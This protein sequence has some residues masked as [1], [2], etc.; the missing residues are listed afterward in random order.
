MRFP[1]CRGGKAGR[2]TKV[3]AAAVLV[4]SLGWAAPAL[5]QDAPAARCGALTSLAGPTLRIT[6]ARLIPAGPLRTRRPP[7]PGMTPVVLPAHC[8]VR[9]VLNPRTGADGRAY[10]LGFELRMPAKW[11]GRFLFQGGAGLDGAVRP[12]VGAVA[13]GARPA[14]VRGFAVISSDGGHEGMDASFA[15][16]QQAKLDYAYAGLG[17]VAAL[18]KKIVAQYY[19]KKASYSYF[20]GC[21]NGGREAMMAA[22][23][24]PGAFNGIVAGDPGFNLSAAAIAE[25]WDVKHLMAIAPKD[26]QGRPILSEALTKADL[27]LVSHAVLVACDGLDGLKDGM[28]N[29]MAACHFDPKVLACK[30]GHSRP[31]LALKKVAAIEAMFRGPHDSQ[32]RPLYAN[33]PYDAG[34]DT[35]GWRM[36]RL[37]TS[38][39]AKPNAM[40]ATLGLNSMRFYFL[41][42]PQPN[43]TPETFDFDRARAD[44]EKT[45]AINDVT[46]MLTS[47][48]AHGGK[49][50]VY[51]GLSDP[52]FSADAI[53]S[54][55]RRLEE[56]DSSAYRWA[57]LFLVPG[58]NHCFGGPA[59]DRFDAL[60]AIQRWTEAAK[61]PTRIVAHGR[62]FPKVHRP[63]CPYPQYA[64][65]KGGDVTE[66]KSF[67]CRIDKADGS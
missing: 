21:S 18:G 11:N 5:A 6:S 36:W 9:G 33:W 17:P 29:N 56:K 22:E 45:R 53:M 44:T 43:M 30:N 63:L 24:F 49:L 42:P 47:Y 4:S 23:R 7:F 66:A 54:W 10:G 37:G 31:C 12:A 48:A 34:I 27:S 14:L 57:R 58:M 64:H 50:I 3:F 35:M 39:T 38:K 41:T 55:Y 67:V 62:A 32:G 25:M 61:P 40:D 13:A 16:D 26:A 8:L 59:T 2:I 60:S 52:V 28:I 15:A 1:T 65:Y 19:G 51:Q 20:V 46:G